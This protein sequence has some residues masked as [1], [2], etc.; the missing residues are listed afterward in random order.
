MIKRSHYD[1]R[2]GHAK[3][4]RD[5]R[6]H[7]KPGRLFMSPQSTTQDLPT[8]VFVLLLTT[9]IRHLKRLDV[10]CL[11]TSIYAVHGS[12]VARISPTTCPLGYVARP[13]LGASQAVK[14][15]VN[16]YVT[17]ALSWACNSGIVD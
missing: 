4:G 17:D 3:V 2:F 12:Y 8:H 13:Y 15:G 6:V 10:R 9:V 7:G 5:S 16:V 14:V 11:D 1:P